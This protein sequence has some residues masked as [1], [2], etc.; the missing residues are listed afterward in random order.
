MI[1]FISSKWHD[2][3]GLFLVSMGSA[4]IVFFKDREIG[5]MLIG[6]GL[7]VFNPQPSTVKPSA[8]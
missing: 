5:L 4:M 3:C 8:S 1:N 6:G 7:A 2:L